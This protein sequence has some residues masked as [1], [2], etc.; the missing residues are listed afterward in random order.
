MESDSPKNPLFYKMCLKVR[1]FENVCVTAR[2]GADT[3][4]MR[5]VCVGNDGGRWEWVG[6]GRGQ[7]QDERYQ[8]LL[9][10]WHN[11]VNFAGFSDAICSK[12]I[13]RRFEWYQSTRHVH[14]VIFSYYHRK[15][16]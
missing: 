1:F 8:S 13:F 16:E 11:G 3:L 4:C 12:V 6:E 15:S 7:P 14:A 10:P 2:D 9:W 5:T